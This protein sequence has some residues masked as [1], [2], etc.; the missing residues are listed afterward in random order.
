[1]LRLES[2]P[3]GQQKSLFGGFQNKEIHQWSLLKKLY[4][5]NN[6]H[7]ANLSRVIKQALFF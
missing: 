1:M 7:L 2:T 5:K 4:E 3:E 6:L